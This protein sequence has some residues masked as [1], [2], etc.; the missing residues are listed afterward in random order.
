MDLWSEGT[1]RP[2][3]MPGGFLLLVAVVLLQSSLVSAPPAAIDSFYYVVFAAGIALAWRF[4]SSRVLF[5]LVVLLLAHRA[6]E[7]F[8][9][10]RAASAGSAESRSRQSRFYCR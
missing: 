1:L 8:S 9:V 2:L 4:H 7:F 5:A 6:V 10:G 3:L